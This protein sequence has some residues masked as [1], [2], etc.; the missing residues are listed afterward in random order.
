MERQKV[1]VVEV[2]DS[3]GLS[4]LA[5]RLLTICGLVVL[6]D[7]FDTQAI[8]FAAS[9]MARDL[10]I[11][12][13]QFGPIFS[14]GLFGAM[15]GALFLSPLSDR[16]GRKPTL[17]AAIAFFSVFTL[18]T[19]F[20]TTVTELVVAR[21]MAG[22]GL[23]GAI[24]NVI[25]LCSEYAPRSKRGMAIGL[26]YAGFPL[27]GMIGGLSAAK[28]IPALGWHSIFF[29]GGVLPLVLVILVILTIPESWQ[30]MVGKP[31][32]ASRLN[33]VM[34]RLD[35]RFSANRDYV[36]TEHTTEGAALSRLFADGRLAGTLL[37]WVPFF[38]ILLLLV[39]MV[40]WT[41]ALLKEAGISSEQGAIITALINLGSAVGT[42]IIGRLID[43]IGP[44]VIIPVVIAVGA[45]CVAPMGLMTDSPLA[46]AALAVSGGFFVGSAASGL[47]V[48]AALSYPVSVRATG[49]GW[50][51]SMGRVG[52]VVGPI[53]AGGLLA[54]GFKVDQIFLFSVAPAAAAI[55]AVVLL[56]TQRSMRV[57]S[58]LS[59]IEKAS[60]LAE[61]H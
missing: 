54:A 13:Q 36:S 51:Y 31:K 43:K 59:T 2:I 25:S 5:K 35:P 39:V 9:S 55:L 44:Y 37:L 50:A 34:Q 10:N 38:M 12:I 23:G 3:Q 60:A 22:I 14:A 53:A 40:L 20:S 49:V 41:P 33:R 42:A 32:H 1:S 6:I 21:F 27:G 24:P 61:A 4:P 19:A 48:L 46:L 29:I 7:G 52:Q 45:A 16:F 57:S 30:F 8:G 26:L 56:R 11:P 17:V 28:L 47:L 58:E 15:L 18:L